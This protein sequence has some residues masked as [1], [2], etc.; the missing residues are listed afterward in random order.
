MHGERHALWGPHAE[1]SAEDKALLGAFTAG[2]RQLPGSP[3]PP[4]PVCIRSRRTICTHPIQR[5]R[6]CKQPRQFESS[7]S[8]FDLK[9][10]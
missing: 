1:A 6:R 10:A 3:L 8:D 7:D 2:N 5:A 4:H 9:A